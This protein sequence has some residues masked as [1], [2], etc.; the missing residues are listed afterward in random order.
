MVGNIPTLARLLGLPYIP[1]TPFFPLL[2]P[3]G[4][5]PLPSKWI[6]EFGEPI[7]TDK[8]GAGRRRRPDAGLQPHRPGPRDH[9][10]DALQAAAAAPQRL[11]LARC[12]LTVGWSIPRACV[13]S[14]SAAATARAG[15]RGCGCAAW[16]A[17][18]RSRRRPRRRRRRRVRRPSRPCGRCGSR[19]SP[20]R[21]PARSRLSFASGFTATGWPTA[22]SIGRS[23]AESEYAEHCVRSRPSCSASARIASA[24]AGPC[25]GSPTSRPV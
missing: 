11:L 16:R 2:G 12:R 5:I 6:I 10:A 20:S 14:R 8:I 22:V 21:S 7:E 18:P 24:F 4:L 23:L 19:G 9:P 15:D 25:S 17:R 1:I 3:L 13:S